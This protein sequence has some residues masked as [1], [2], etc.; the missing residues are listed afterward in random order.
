MA[1]D[2]LH[3]YIFNKAHV[4]GEMVRLQ[5]SYQAILDSY[6]YPEVIQTLLSNRTGGKERVPEDSTV[7]RP[8]QKKPISLAPVD[9]PVL[10]RCLKRKSR[11]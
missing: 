9:K 2:Q 7:S 4:R 8:K 6:A 11:D 3:R 5:D 1:F 10:E